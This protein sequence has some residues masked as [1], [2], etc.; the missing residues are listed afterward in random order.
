MRRV[1]AIIPALNEELAIGEVV[2]EIPARLVH[3]IIVVDN[4]STDRTA[5]VARAAGAR[6]GAR[7]R[8]PGLPRRGPERRSG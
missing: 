8:H 5:E 7:R 2:R 6:G 1:T 4:G 3:E